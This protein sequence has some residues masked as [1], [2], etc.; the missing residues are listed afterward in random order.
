M[1][2]DRSNVIGWQIAKDGFSVHGDNPSGEMPFS[3]ASFEVLRGQ[4][5]LQ[6]VRW[7]AANPGFSLLTICENDIEE[8]T[9]VE[10]W[11]Q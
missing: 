7:M 8:P 10:I 4:A 3:F 1:I 11:S 9:F 6:A 5:V 2:A